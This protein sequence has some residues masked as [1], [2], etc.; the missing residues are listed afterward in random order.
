MSLWKNNLTLL[1]N[2]KNIKETANCIY[3]MGENTI[4]CLDDIGIPI[5]FSSFLGKENYECD[6]NITNCNF[7]NKTAEAL[8][9]TYLLINNNYSKKVAEIWEEKMK[10]IINE[11]N[12]KE[13]ELN[14]NYR[15]DFILE[16][17]ISDNLNDQ[18]KINK[19][20]II[21][22][23]SIMF[24]YILISMGKFPS[25]IYSK[26]Y[27]SFTG[28]IIIILSCLGSFSIVS[29]LGYKLSIISIQVIPI[30]MLIIG[31]DNMYIIIDARDRVSET[32]KK[33]KEKKGYIYNMSN[34]EQ[35]GTALKE[36][37]PNITIVSF[38]E[39]LSFYIGYLMNIPFLQSFCLCGIFSILINYILQITIFV[40]CISLD[41]IRIE[42][43]RYDLFP[44]I[45]VNENI[46]VEH[47]IGKVTLQ[48]FISEGYYNILVET[49]CKIFAIIFYLIIIILSI[50]SVSLYEFGLDH[51]ILVTKNSDL[52][53]YLD[54]QKKIF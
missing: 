34:E 36:I 17:S 24:I 18:S 45:T 44:C 41:D 38:V 39:I 46:Y 33:L 7:C 22:S 21:I 50:F 1:K 35:I 5:K 13:N 30:F 2:T 12:K 54:T 49:K 32:L 28:I 37:S 16:K 42:N 52:F 23:Y 48:K 20:T 43:R 6:I 25:L 27:L 51:R 26:I 11:F 8:S 9:I 3:K 15:V 31:I 47:S 4:P 53:N 40:S 14:T 29:F 19:F 10:N